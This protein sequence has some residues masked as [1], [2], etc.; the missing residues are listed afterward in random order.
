MRFIKTSNSFVE[1]VEADGNGN[2]ITSRGFQLGS[3]YFQIKNGRV[4]F[5]LNDSDNPYTNDVW[6]TNIPLVIDDVEYSTPEAVT[7]ALGAI[8]NSNLQDQIDELSED[9]AAESARAEASEAALDDAID[10]ERDRATSAETHLSDAITA[11]SGTVATYDNRIT[12]AQE[13]ARQAF[14]QTEA[15]IARSTA[16]D[17]A[18]DTAISGLTTSVNNEI[19]RALSAETSLH[20][21]VLSE[22][23]RAQAAESG[24]TANLNAE[25][26]N[27]QADVDAEE[28]RAIAA[29]SALTDAINAEETARETADG[30]ISGAVDTVSS[31]LANEVQRAQN[32]E[33]GLTNS[34]NTVSGN[35]QS[36][37]ARATSMENAID[38]K[39]DNE[40]TR[41]T[42]KDAAHDA[43]ISGLTT[44]LQ[45]EITRATGAENSLRNDLN[46][47]V[48]AR[49]TADAAQL[50]RITALEVG[51]ADA[52]SVYTK[53]ES[54]TLLAAK[55]DKA[56]AVATAE[57][58]SQNKTINFKNINGTVLSTIDATPFV[59]DGMLDSV[60]IVNGNLVFVWNTD[61]GK[62]TV[63]IPLT[64]IFNPSNYY[65]KTATDAL[66]ATKLN[67]SEFNTYSGVTKTSIDSKLNTSDFNTYSAATENVL[68][69]VYLKSE[70]S[71]ATQISSALAEKLDAT[72]YTPTDLSNYY[73]KDETSGKTEIANALAEKLNISD[74]NTYSGNV[75]TA[76]SEKASQSTVDTLNGVV[77][78]HTAD[79][80]IHLTSG[81]VQS[82]ID[83]S[84]SGKANSSDVYLKTETSGATELATAFAATQPKLSAGTGI[85]ITS[86]VISV[87]ASSP[88]VDAYTKAESDA[89][90]ATITNF[91]SHSGNTDIHVTASEKQTWNAKQNALTA[92]SGI[93][94]QNDVISVTGGTSGGGVVPISQNIASGGT[95]DDLIRLNYF[96]GG[97]VIKVATI[98]I[99]GSD[100][101][102]WIGQ[103]I[104]P[105]AYDGTITFETTNFGIQYL[106]LVINDINTFNAN[107][108]GNLT[109]QNDGS[110]YYFDITYD[111]LTVTKTSYDSIP[112]F[113]ENCNAL[114]SIVYN[115]YTGEKTY[116]PNIDVAPIY[117]FDIGRPIYYTAA[118]FKE[119]KA[120][121]SAHTA[122]TNV[123]V[124]AQDK[125]NWNNKSNFS[126]SY[127]DLT[128]KPT[129][130][131]SASQ[132]TND[133]GY[134][135]SNDI[136]GKTDV[137]A[138]TSHTADTTV[139]V[140]AA[141]K[142]TWNNKPNVWSGSEQQ[143]AQI[144]GG[145]LDNNTIYL[146]Y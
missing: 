105:S 123:H 129:I 40:V 144:S 134:I 101:L 55:A 34:I 14:E 53:S 22:A 107:F 94:I 8:M 140:T 87:T 138:F 135:T 16:K 75:A 26:T 25:I 35:V 4:T 137:T 110:R 95:V 15:E 118:N 132:L 116:T 66:L 11:L 47:E 90:F 93:S 1:F 31:G 77:T 126:G 80:S 122:N 109:P 50:Q 64:D 19:A 82:Q 106:Y 30:V 3:V 133:A 113:G 49:T 97:E 125:T 86:N 85:D 89:K 5:Y 120:I 127:N 52:N 83:S 146:I 81:N 48:S 108:T 9:L 54:D 119:Q 100:M 117:K 7:D 114:F 121:L 139:H 20:N 98:N 112:F 56:N 69:N 70:T 41:A 38:T 73:T 32:A 29:E 96:N 136:T 23:S 36:E 124:T 68:D 62:Q 115:D 51:K 102:G 92:G 17:A 59:V 44:S 60:S 111:A 57:Y 65:D 131:T 91:N 45:N 130:P 12:R 58:V 103:C 24:I 37:I 84:I 145:T 74:F 78:A 79:T 27:R 43:E 128:N 42:A 104:G 142:S 72:A 67:T 99:G 63:S 18:H 39:I 46:A 6:T 13:D 33:S 143:W 76:L 2:V 88:S 10:D 21:E 28:A 141:E 71:G 61:S